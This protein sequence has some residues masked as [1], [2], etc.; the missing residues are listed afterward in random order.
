MVAE[1]TT[2]KK[3][4]KKRK[5]P[6]SQSL[7]IALCPC[8][9]SPLNSSKSAG[10]AT[11]A[12]SLPAFVLRASTPLMVRGSGRVTAVVSVRASVCIVSSA[13]GAMAC[14]CVYVYVDGYKKGVE[15]GE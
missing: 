6:P 11:P 12:T 2:Q 13:W 5:N 7:A 14:V 8:D 10:A 9:P 3:N 1:N 4:K 15:S